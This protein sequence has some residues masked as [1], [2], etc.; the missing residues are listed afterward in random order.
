[1]KKVKLRQFLS[2]IVFFLSGFIMLFILHFPFIA[3]SVSFIF[4]CLAFFIFRIMYCKFAIKLRAWR[5]QHSKLVQY[6][7]S[8]NFMAIVALIGIIVLIFLGIVPGKSPT[9]EAMDFPV[10]D[11]VEMLHFF[12]QL[13][14]ARFSAVSHFPSCLLLCSGDFL[15]GLLGDLVPRD[16]ATFLQAKRKYP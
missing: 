2:L 14:T 8:L 11:A 7:F 9:Y 16:F 3:V 12:L 1:M 6:L 13:Y 5:R 15:L 4:S 10:P